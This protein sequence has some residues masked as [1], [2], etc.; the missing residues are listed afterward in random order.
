[1]M[2]VL[3]ITR[4]FL[5]KLNE[6]N[7]ILDGQ[8]VLRNFIVTNHPGDTGATVLAELLAMYTENAWLRKARN[9]SFL[10]YPTMAQLLPTLNDPN[11]EWDIQI[12]H[13]KK[14]ANTF[15]PAADVAA[16][17]HWFRLANSTNVFDGLTEALGAAKRLAALAMS[18]LE[19]SIGNFIH[20]H[21]RPLNENTTMRLP[22][23]E[24]I[25]EA[26]LDYFMSVERRD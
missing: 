12:Y 23:R 3:F 10:H 8:A 24:S 16:N 26:K 17:L 9:Q 2:Q 5:G 14:T 25:F 21:L 18:A 7:V 6:L 13:G 22:V 15:Y 19:Q 1:M 20:L 4:M 11:V